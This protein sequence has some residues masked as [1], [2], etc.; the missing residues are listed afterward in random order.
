MKFTQEGFSL[1]KRFEGC[2]LKAYPDP[3]SPLG[4]ATIA[5]KLSLR[6]YHKLPDWKTLEG[7]PWTIGFGSTHGV[8]EGMTITQL[9]ANNRL[10]DDIAGTELGIRRFIKMPLTDNQYS[11]CVSLAFNIGVTAFRNST[12]LALINQGKLSEVPKE[13]PKWRLAGGKVSGGLINRRFAE[14]ALFLRG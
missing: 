10:A 4:L 6:D 11:A 12:L 1:I 5:R 2:I 7:A 14:Q 8:V 9:E 3:Y 13:F